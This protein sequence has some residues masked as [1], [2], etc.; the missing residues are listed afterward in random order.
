MRWAAIDAAAFASNNLYSAALYLTRQAYS[1]NHTILGYGELDKLLQRTDQYHALPA[2]VAQWVLKQVCPAWK[3]YFA[4]CQEWEVSAKEFQGHPKL[5]KYRDKQGRNLLTSTIQAISCHPKNAGWI[6]PSGL[7][8]RVAPV[9]SLDATAQV[10][11]VPHTTHYTVQ[12]SYERPLTSADLD[13]PWVAGMDLDV[14][15]LATLSTNQP[16]FTPLLVNGRSR[17]SLNQLY[18]KRCAYYHSPLPTG[19]HT[20]RRLD[21]L[22]DKR[23]RQV[24]SYLHVASRRVMDYLVQQRIR[25][26]V[27]GKNDGLKQEVALGKRTN[28]TFTFLPYARFIA[29]LTY[30]ARL[31]GIDVVLT[32]ESDASKCSV[33]DGEPLTQQLEYVGKRVKRGVFV[34]AMGR[35]INADVDASYT[36]STTVVPNAFGNGR[37]CRSS[38][39]QAQPGK[40]AAGVIACW[41]DRNYNWL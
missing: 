16:G 20:S 11:I 34:I 13:L 15:N 32:G 5:P 8:I 40:L 28:Q 36:M 17:K 38:P 26:L 21:C 6:V 27:I 29:M 23:K 33:L 7:P 1:T 12:V 31:V 25:T 10:R 3:T 41:T 2:K 39:R 14:N 4:A 19:R 22:A 35:Q 18:H 24:D 9:Q 37:G 30:K